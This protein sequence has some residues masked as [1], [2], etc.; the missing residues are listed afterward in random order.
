MPPWTTTRW[1]GLAAT[2]T[3]LGYQWWRG[4]PIAGATGPT[5][6]SA[7]LSAA[8]DGAAFH[9]VVS[10]AYGGSVTRHGS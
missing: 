8:D 1:L 2:G 3:E 5:Y 10:D 9:A 7:S 4:A 6:T